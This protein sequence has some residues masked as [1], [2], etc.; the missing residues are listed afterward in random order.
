MASGCHLQLLT[1]K[2]PTPNQKKPH[3]KETAI[4]IVLMTDFVCCMPG[5]QKWKMQ[6]KK[7]LF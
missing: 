7:I 5:D 1:K 4:P 2:T 6:G 3:S